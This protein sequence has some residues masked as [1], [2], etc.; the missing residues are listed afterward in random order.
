MSSENG[1]YYTDADYNDL[2]KRYSELE[3]HHS[4]L[5]HQNDEVVAQRDRLLSD[6]AML[7]DCVTHL[8]SAL[9]SSKCQN[10][11][12]QMSRFEMKE[13]KQSEVTVTSLPKPLSSAPDSGDRYYIECPTATYMYRSEI[14]TNSHND[15][16][17]LKRSI[18]YDN[19]DDAIDNCKARYG[20]NG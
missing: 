4:D 8:K 12:L 15:N 13:I 19:P 20:I 1:G 3:G 7:K 14:W 2:Q 10:A 6:K 5:I 18:C 11:I 17:H 9:E 16:L